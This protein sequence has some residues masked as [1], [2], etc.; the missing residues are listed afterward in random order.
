MDRVRALRA[1]N[2]RIS[3]NAGTRIERGDVFT[4]RPEDPV[5]DWIRAGLV[6]PIA[7]TAQNGDA[8]LSD[9]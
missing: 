6:K 1:F 2:L 7:D 9:S 4:V 5:N 8:G 3:S